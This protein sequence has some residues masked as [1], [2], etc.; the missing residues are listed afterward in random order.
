MAGGPKSLDARR[1]E[2]PLFNTQVDIANAKFLAANPTKDS[3]WGRKSRAGVAVTFI[4]PA[5]TGGW[6]PS[7]TVIESIGYYSVWPTCALS[8]QPKRP[9][10]IPSHSSPSHPPLWAHP[11]ARGCHPSPA[12]ARERERD[13]EETEWGSYIPTSPPR[14]TLTGGGPATI[15]KHGSQIAVTGCEDQLNDGDESR[16]LSDASLVEKDDDGKPIKK[17]K[18]NGTQ[19]TTIERSKTGSTACVGLYTCGSWLCYTHYGQ[20]AGSAGPIVRGPEVVAASP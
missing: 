3:K 2:A 11:F 16:T 14:D 10:R 4:N 6:E 5:R 8:Q 7:C 1:I 12:W 19:I 20:A 15:T 18:A 9:Q 17:R 13:R